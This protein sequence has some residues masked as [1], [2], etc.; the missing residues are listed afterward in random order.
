MV[1]APRKILR[2]ERPLLD[3]D[4]MEN[5]SISDESR[6]ALGM[7]LALVL[8]LGPAFSG[9]APAPAPFEAAAVA[10]HT[11]TSALALGALPVALVSGQ[12]WMLQAM[13]LFPLALLL[14]HFL[15]MATMRHLHE[16]WRATRTAGAAVAKTAARLTRR[17]P[18]VR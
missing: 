7:V 13:L 18:I 8:V 11:P 6:A 4:R 5:R 17:L 15:I 2:P 16:A 10:S 3:C 14:L 12:A 1:G 9:N